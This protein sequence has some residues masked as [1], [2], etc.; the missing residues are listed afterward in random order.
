[1]HFQYKRGLQ[2]FARFLHAAVM[3]ATAAR[4]KKLVHVPRDKMGNYGICFSISITSHLIKLPNSAAIRDAAI[5][6]I[7]ITK[8]LVLLLTVIA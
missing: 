6:A 3:H 4:A 2:N 7:A 1:M 5:M 8:N